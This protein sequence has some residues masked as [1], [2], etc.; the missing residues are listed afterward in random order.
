MHV[1]LYAVSKTNFCENRMGKC[2]ESRLVSKV[3]C[4]VVEH[5]DHIGTRHKEPWDQPVGTK[6][7][8]RGKLDLEQCRDLP[9]EAHPRHSSERLPDKTADRKPFAVPARVQNE[10]LL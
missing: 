4:I 10:N 6:V 3:M 5:L 7:D 2:S 9:G 1:C 8:E